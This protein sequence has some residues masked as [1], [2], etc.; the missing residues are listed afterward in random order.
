NQD[1]CGSTVEQSAPKYLSPAL[2]CSPARLAA[3]VAASEASTSSASSTTTRINQT[4]TAS[5]TPTTAPR[6]N[7]RSRRNRVM[8]RCTLPGTV[9]AAVMLPAQRHA[10]VRVAP[11]LAERAQDRVIELALA[12]EQAEVK[13][14]P[15]ELLGWL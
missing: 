3:T 4:A 8:G 9:Q 15:V 10:A 14:A 1:P 12:L 11:A 6:A 5:N 2:R 13:P 7:H